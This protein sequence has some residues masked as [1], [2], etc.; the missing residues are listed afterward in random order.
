MRAATRRSSRST[1]AKE[2]RSVGPL[3]EFRSTICPDEEGS[4]TVAELVLAAEV[5]MEGTKE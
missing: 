5:Q 4:G 1:T 3:P 2:P